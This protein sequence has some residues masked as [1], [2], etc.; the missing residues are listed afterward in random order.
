MVQ[1]KSNE[2]PGKITKLMDKVESGESVQIMKSGRPIAVLYPL[3][4]RGQ[5]W[6][7]DIKKIKLSEKVSAQAYIEEERDIS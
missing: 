6:K 2:L 3:V 4:S 7:R 1:V 5:G